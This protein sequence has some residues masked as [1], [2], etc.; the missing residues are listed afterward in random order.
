MLKN[1]VRCRKTIR[2]R[3]WTLIQSLNAWPKLGAK[4][5]CKAPLG[6]AENQLLLWPPHSPRQRSALAEVGIWSQSIAWNLGTLMWNAG[7]LTIFCINMWVITW[8]LT[9]NSLLAFE[10]NE[11]RS[12]AVVS[13]V[14]VNQMENDMFSLLFHIL[15]CTFISSK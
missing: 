6:R 4:T 13:K 1:L 15:F 8:F 9:V 5:Q 12:M 10:N 3:P 14:S 2:E 11:H 7:V